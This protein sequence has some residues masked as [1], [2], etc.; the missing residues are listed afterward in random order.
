L[1]RSTSPPEMPGTVLRR[2][3]SSAAWSEMN[4]SME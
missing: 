3:S 1:T 2:K 4:G